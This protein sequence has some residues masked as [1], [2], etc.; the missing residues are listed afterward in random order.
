MTTARIRPA[1][2]TATL[3]ASACL[4]LT[5]C[6]GSGT[7]AA[8]ASA[9][10]SG[11][12]AA[13][14]ASAGAVAASPVSDGGPAATATASAGVPLA[15]DPVR[16]TAES[17][18]ASPAEAQPSDAAT[19]TYDD[20]VKLTN[21][22]GHTCTLTGFPTVAVAGEGDPTRNRPLK[23]TRRGTA[24]PVRL[25]PGHSAWLR[26]TFRVVMGEADGYCASGA[27]PTSAPTLVIGGFANGG[28][29]QIGSVNR[30]FGECD[31]VVWVA[32]FLGTR[33]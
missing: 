2:V 27:T 16:C 26:L 7:S 14:S 1:T 17:L 19:S 11:A 6:Q 23:V 32:P 21:T 25:A 4:L 8:S 29:I 15:V 31:D 13:S 18:T 9:P 30:G 10:S 12:S 20:F 3:L 33:P 24:H 22:G 5:A 28:A